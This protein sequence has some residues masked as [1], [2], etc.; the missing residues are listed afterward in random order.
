[1]AIKWK[2]NKSAT[3]ETELEN[4][5][6]KPK[7]AKVW[8]G[9]LLVCIFIT[10]VSVATYCMQPEV[11]KVREKSEKAKEEQLSEQ[12]DKAL[13]DFGYCSD[14][15]KM[16]LISNIYY[17]N[18]KMENMYD[19]LSVEEYLLKNNKEYKNLTDAQAK[20]NYEEKAK[21]L[22]NILYTAYRMDYSVGEGGKT[23]TY[24]YDKK[25]G[26]SSGQEDLAAV[27][28]KEDL[29][30]IQENYQSYMVIDF[31]EK[32]NPSI[33]TKYNIEEANFLNYLK[34]IRI[35][36]VA[37]YYATL[38]EW[39]IIYDVETGSPLEVYW[40][41]QENYKEDYEFEDNYEEVV[42]VVVP[43]EEEE[44]QININFPK[45]KDTQVV[46]AFGFG[47]VDDVEYYLSVQ[48]DQ[49]YDLCYLI[50]LCFGIVV[51]AGAVVLQNLPVLGL[52]QQQI[53]RMPTELILIAGFVGLLIYCEEEL[54]YIIMMEIKEAVQYWM[55]DSQFVT[56]AVMLNKLPSVINVG[57]WLGFYA[58]AYWIIANVLP[59]VL[60]P[61]K[62]IKENSIAV[63]IIRY[64]L[65]QCKRC[66]VYITTIE[67]DKGLKKNIIKI[68]AANAVLVCLFCCVWFLGIFGVILYTIILY[69]VLVKKGSV[70][71]AQYDKLLSMVTDMAQGELNVD[72]SENLGI[73][74]PVKQELSKVRMGFQ[75]AVEEE[76]KSQNMK[77]ELITNVSHDLKTPLTAIITYVD[78]L[79]NENLEE[80]TRKEY[81][82]T[83]D[84]KSQR[85]KV[86]IED[87][88][89]V[90]KA[91]SNNITMHYAD[92]DLVNLVKQVRLENEERIM[93]SDLVFRWNLPEEKCVLRLDPQRTYRVIENLLVNALK[94]SMSGSRVYVEVTDGEENVLFT[95][96]NISATELNIEADQLTER[97]VRGDV[98]RNTEG[99]GLGLAIARSFTELQNGKFSVEIDGDL[100]KVTVQFNK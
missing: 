66:Y 35:Q 34:N 24:M 27:I 86:L 39:E 9:Y 42:A 63:K 94:Y 59:Y 52:K 32:G 17:L 80:E 95:M 57:L 78:L 71:K 77:T 37:D 19:G 53:F 75:H 22:I 99:S 100:F 23:F 3:K 91:S 15:D 6:K 97:F 26:I 48:Y 8:L 83:L 61:I 64:I 82:A 67:A 46:I 56:E 65:K 28:Q 31:D 50:T 16:S 29:S 81:I 98:S 89:E 88:F 49:A 11:Q 5:E 43:E 60:H 74:E 69:F 73:F 2:N 87:L 93:D 36:A 1:M 70:I 30:T 13:V 54:P 44:E 21:E 72:V 68:L 10:V 18:Y 41:Q 20:K 84:K 7:K 33:T 47:I 14:R 76:V 58:V 38:R 90:S 92:V 79:K 12:K 62:N 96:K 40:E 85:L 45:I 55:N 25:R 51:L 4:L